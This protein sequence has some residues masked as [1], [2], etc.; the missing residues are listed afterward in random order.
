MLNTAAGITQYV[1]CQMKHS[2][3]GKNT[4]GGVGCIRRTESVTAVQTVQLSNPTLNFHVDYSGLRKQK[5]LDMIN[6]AGER[7][8][9]KEE[10]QLCGEAQLGERDSL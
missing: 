5:R 8:D 1:F 4:A 6:R 3:E 10:K 9:N 2:W 7:Q